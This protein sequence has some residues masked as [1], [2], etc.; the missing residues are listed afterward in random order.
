MTDLGNF[1]EQT[2]L[3]ELIIAVISLLSVYL[4]YAVKNAKINLHSKK[5]KFTEHQLFNNLRN[6]IREVENW[7]VPENKIVFKDALLVK[8]KIWLSSGLDFTKELQT[9]KVRR[10]NLET[11]F[12]N[13][14]ESA[15]NTYVSDWDKMQIP[16]NVIRFINSEHQNKVN[17][18]TSKIRNISTCKHFINNYIKTN[19]ILETLDT[20]LA[21]TKADFLTIT[22]MKNL[23]GRF[24]NDSYKGVP[25]S[26]IK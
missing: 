11:E 26:D 14:L 8:L 15:V 1:L 19:V 6:T 2:G 25:I 9:K 5:V 24:K 3:T 10:L 7:N 4:G 13:W 21:E 12:L 23:N 16:S 17:S 20:L 18:F 22:F